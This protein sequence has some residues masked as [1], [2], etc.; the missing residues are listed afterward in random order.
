MQ[1]TIFNVFFAF[2]IVGI[3]HNFILA[4]SLE[5]DSVEINIS[6]Y[7]SGDVQ[8]Q[9]SQDSI[10]WLDLDG[11][12][13]P[14][15]LISSTD[16]NFYRAV[17]YVGTCEPYYSDGIKNPKSFSLTQDEID[18]ILAAGTETE[19]E[20][21][22]IFEHPD[23]NIL[24]SISDPL[25]VDCN[26]D[27]IVHMKERMYLTVTDPLNTGVGIAAPQVGINRRACWI[28]RYDKAPWWNP[29]GA[30]FEFY[31]NPVITARSDTLVQRADGCL[32]VPQEAG[33]P[34]MPDS[35]YRAIWVDVEYQ[36]LD[37]TTITERID[38]EY[39]AHIF[40]HELDHLDGIMY[41]ERSQIN[42]FKLFI[43]P[44]S[45]ESYPLRGM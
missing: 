27:E 8:W 40:Q 44:E 5:C 21:M 30:P 42:N 31:V 24:V 38:H 1:K 22:N 39:T 34:D 11:E 16:T 15:L 43:L 14:E 17:I 7:T 32:S 9:I 3:F 28:Q 33:Y 41:M 12:N 26:Y 18:L 25:S 6:G 36:L 13:N 23:S 10:N 4:Q 35:T 2:A 19:M 20:V 29:F 45:S 37:G